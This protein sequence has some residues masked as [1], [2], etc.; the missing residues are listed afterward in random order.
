MVFIQGDLQDTAMGV[1]FDLA[2]NMEQVS[3][4][5]QAI[6][7]TPIGDMP[8]HLI[9][10]PGNQVASQLGQQ[11]QHFLSREGHTEDMRRLAGKVPRTLETLMDDPSSHVRMRAAM[12]VVRANGLDELPAPEPVDALDEIMN[13]ALDILGEEMGLAL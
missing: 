3:H 13:G 4:Y 10:Y 12:A 6:E 2:W 7:S 8:S 11:D 1:Q 9:A 5:T